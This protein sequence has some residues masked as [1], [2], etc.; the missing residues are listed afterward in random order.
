MKKG[1]IIALGVLIV[2]AIGAY[3]GY[4]RLRHEAAAE[5]GPYDNTLKPRLELTRFDFTN[6]SDDTITMTM[7][8]LV[9][10]PLPVG[11]K[12]HRLDYTFYIA[13]TP[14]VID[15]YQK[16]IEVK[17]GDSTLIV[18]PAKLFSKKMTEVLKTLERKNI[19][20]T[21]YKVRTT[22]ALDLPV[23]GEKTFA[24]TAEKRLPT[25]YIPKVKVENIRFGKLGLKEADVAAKVSVINK[26]KFPYNITDTHY[27]VSIDGKKIAEGDQ[28]E[29]IL[30]KAQATTPVVFPVSGKPGKTLSVLPKML[31]DKKDT[32]YVI[33]FRCKVLDKNNNPTFKNSKFI[34]TIKGTLDD[35]KKKK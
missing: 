26:N 27:T 32:P 20:S 29:P 1:W 13:N 33:D 4:S 14:V 24:T 10:N 8:M 6:I 31:F 7:Y 12:A 17:P 21:T 34:A 22:F 23:L 18:M 28:P 3:V 30:I 35:F 2:A 15:S 5:T 25:Y 19:D 11:F 16:P 9:D